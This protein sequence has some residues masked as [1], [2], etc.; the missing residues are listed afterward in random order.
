MSPL[1]DVHS[2]SISSALTED[3][4]QELHTGAVVHCNCAAPPRPGGCI[5]ALDAAT[6]QREVGLVM[7]IC[8]ATGAGGG[9]RT[10]RDHAVHEHGARPLPHTEP[11]AA[12]TRP[13]VHGRF[14]TS[15][16]RHRVPDAGPLHEQRAACAVHEHA[17]PTR[18]GVAIDDVDLSQREA[19]AGGHFDGARHALGVEDRPLGADTLER[20]VD[21]SDHEGR[22]AE[23]VAAGESDHA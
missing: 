17:A 8:T 23:G 19:P 2:C 22:A 9:T 7:D 14:T 6:T 15:A 13:L 12:V 1:V 3:A 5:A 20:Q 10:V 16:G 18:R 11:A 21:A 4:V